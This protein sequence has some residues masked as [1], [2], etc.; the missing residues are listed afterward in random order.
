MFA[1]WKLLPFV[2]LLPFLG[3]LN[4]GCSQNEQGNWKADAQFLADAGFEVE[5][6]IIY[7]TGHVAG[8]AFNLTG[9]NGIVRAQMKPKLAPS[10]PPAQ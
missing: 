6:T 1:N 2:L 9:S 5:A 4:V 8:Q 3:C 10:A 7:G